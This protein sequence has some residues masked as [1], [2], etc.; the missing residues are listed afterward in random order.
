MGYHIILLGPPNVGKGTY[1]SRLAE[2]LDIPHISTGDLFRNLAASGSEQSER[3]RQILA[4][5][6]L[7]PDE[8]T[9]ALLKARLQQP[10][11][12]NGYILDGFP[13]NLQQA[14]MLEQDH[15]TVDHVLNFAAEDKVIMARMAG[16]ITCKNTECNTIYH[17]KNNPPMRKGICDKC[18]SEVGK[19]E[20]DTEEVMK[21]RLLEYHEKTA[22]LI[23]HYTK[24][25]L[26]TQIDAN[27]GGAQRG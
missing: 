26:L 15:I 2:K 16:R 7:V 6:Q 17:E 12:A 10:D 3:I 13:R 18:G 19:R 25:G 11:C 4:A 1:A 5:G 24:K 21:K 14:E 20:D 22:P 27:G 9:Y 8:E 23:E